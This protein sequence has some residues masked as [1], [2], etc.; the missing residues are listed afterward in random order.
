MKKT[1]LSI[2]A[3]C[4]LFSVAY[5]QSPEAFNYQAIVRD[6]SGIVVKN[7][8]VS[9][10]ISLLKGSATGFAVYSELH[11]PTANGFGL[12]NLQIGKGTVTA[13]D[14]KTIDWSSDT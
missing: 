2:I 13:G 8:S 12:I 6:A 5:S 7:Q 11:Q 4:T 1:I 10:K 9:V 3:I 14:F